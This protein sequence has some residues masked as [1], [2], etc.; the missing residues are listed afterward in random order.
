MPVGLYTSKHKNSVTAFVCPCHWR[1]VQ[2]PAPQLCAHSTLSDS[3]TT[4][5]KGGGQ[6]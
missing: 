4:K 3:F 5:Q 2:K 1:V 6:D